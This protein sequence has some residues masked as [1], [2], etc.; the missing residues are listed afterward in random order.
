MRN[1]APKTRTRFK[2]STEYK[3]LK[4]EQDLFRRRI[5][6]VALLTSKL[7]ENDVDAILVGGQAIDLYT[8]GTFATSD[9]DLLVTNKTV[10]EKLL[11]KFGFGK[12]GGVWFNRDLNIVIQVI[13]TPYSGDLS[14]LKKVRVKDFELRVAAPEDLIIGRL[15]SSKVLN[16]NPQL[17]LEQAVTLLNLFAESIDN[18][19]LDEQAKKNDVEDILTEARR[20]ALKI[21]NR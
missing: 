15:Y 9:I 4:Q 8:G 13:T 18:A 20:Y 1:L 10:T 16:S 19:Y 17:D 7:K 6:F 5:R 11:N 3:K 21:R 2:T 14:R 12:E